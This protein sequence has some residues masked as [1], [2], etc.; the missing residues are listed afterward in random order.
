MVGAGLVVPLWVTIGGM[1]LWYQRPSSPS[2]IP[3]FGLA[4][5]LMLIRTLSTRLGFDGVSQ[6]TWR[7][8][9]HL[10]WNEVTAVDRKTRSITVSGPG[11]SIVI[12]VESFYDSAEAARFIESHLPEKLREPR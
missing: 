3:I 10:G 5:T 2:P 12:P 11:G 8:R 4:L 9:R 7:G 6:W 1:Y